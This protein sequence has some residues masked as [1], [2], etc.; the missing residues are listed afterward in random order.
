MLPE[1]SFKNFSLVKLFLQD[2]LNLNNFHNCCFE[3]ESYCSDY[4][5][6][7]TMSLLYVSSFLISFI[8]SL[9]Y[10]PS[11]IHIFLIQIQFVFLYLAHM[12]VCV[13]TSMNT[14]CSVCIYL[15]L[16]ILRIDYFV[17]HNWLVCLSLGKNSFI[18]RIP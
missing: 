9:P 15:Y 16:C 14:A 18:F 6:L 8:L 13:C 12:C 17:S 5:W 10:K 1:T 7:G 3:K 4:Y 11:Q 2:R